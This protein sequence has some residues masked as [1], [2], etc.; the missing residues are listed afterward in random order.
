MELELR[1]NGVVISVDVATNETLLDMLR[2]EGYYSVR[3]GC[4][5]GACGACTVLIDGVPRPACT[6]LAAQAGGCTISTIEELSAPTP[7]STGLHPL[8]QAF[9]DVGAI[10]CGFCTSGMLLS[11]SALLQKNPSPEEADVRE[12]LSGN[13][14]RCVSY[15]KI[16]Q[17]VLRAAALLRGDDVPDALQHGVVQ[18]IETGNTTKMPVLTASA[19]REKPPEIVGKSMP[20]RTATRFVAGKAAFV[21]DTHIPGML[22]ARVLTSPH[23]HARIRAIDTSEARALSGVYAVLTYKDVPRVPYSVA[24][25]PLLDPGPLDQFLLDEVVRYVGDKVAVVVAETPELAEQALKLIE[26]DYEVLPA[27]LDTRQALQENAPRIHAESDAKGIADASR[28][29]AAQVRADAGNVEQGFAEADLI[30]EGEYVVPLVHTAPLDMLHSLA[31]LDEDGMLVVRSNTESPHHVRRMLSRTLGLP[32]RRI[33]VIGQSVGG[34]YG[35]RQALGLEGLSGLLALA[36]QRPVMLSYPRASAFQSSSVRQQ[37]I[38]RLKSG[39]KQDGTL[40]ANQMILLTSTGA[41]ASHPLAAQQNV[42]SETLALYPCPNM[43]YVAQVL[44]TNLPPAAP[45][46]GY[47]VPQEIFALECH[48]DEIAR[49][50]RLDPVELRRRNWIQAGEEYPLARTSVRGKDPLTFQVEGEALPECVQLVLEKLQWHT[51]RGVFSNGRTRRGVGIALSMLGASHLLPGAA[52]AMVKLNEDGSFDVFVGIGSGDVHTETA[53]MQVIAET[54]GVPVDH[55]LIHTADTATTP[56]SLGESAASAFYLGGGA[57]K[58][59]AEQM[60]RQILTMAGRMLGVMP[61]S[62]KLASGVIS[63][64]TGRTLTVEQIAG[65]AL[66]V[67]NRQLMTSASWKMGQIP[68]SFVAQGVELEVDT[69]TGAVRLLQAV[70]AVDI[71]RVINPLLAEAQIQGDALQAIHWTLSEELSYDQKGQPRLTQSGQYHLPTA[72]DVF[73]LEVHL[74]ESYATNGLSGAKNINGIGFHGMAPAI[75]NALADALG[76]PLVQL[77]LTPERVLRAFHAAGQAQEVKQTT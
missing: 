72:L 31:Y 6:M 8:Q 5:T 21:A 42:P 66:Y 47:G 54:I 23:A 55:V 39:V 30:V 70:S 3:R 74:V 36:T 15:D 60:R 50:L 57:V 34:G 22:Y 52:G 48:M 12:A 61:E 43:R 38:V 56:A 27:I 33:R 45:L 71:G 1:I 44:Y 35:V 76:T 49:R 11:A 37:Y 68:V 59:A 41:Y 25:R 24:E 62:L 17:A 28:N 75:A 4:E 32:V 20:T 53:L 67:E 9:L 26:V 58:R 51:K 2:R 46:Q 14:C 29:V 69:E 40:L 7:A 64:P 77:P 19:M 18:G 65:Y 16:V 63:A 10:R 13:L 73:P